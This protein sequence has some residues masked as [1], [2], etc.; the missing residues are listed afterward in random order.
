MKTN[1]KSMSL[2]FADIETLHERVEQL[3]VEN[4]RLKKQMKG[5]APVELLSGVK[6]SP[7]KHSNYW[8]GIYG[9]CMA[10]ECESLRTQ[11]SDQSKRLEAADY[12]INRLENL[13]CDVLEG[14]NAHKDLAAYRATINSVSAETITNPPKV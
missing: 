1:P 11:L 13:C 4:G 10:C 2:Q 8:I 9:T 14:T 12:V 3:E 6:E 5:M 7:C